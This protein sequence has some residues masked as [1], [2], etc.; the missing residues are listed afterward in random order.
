MRFRTRKQSLLGELI[1]LRAPGK[2][3]SPSA[4]SF[5]SS[6]VVGAS[7]ADERPPRTFR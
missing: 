5:F 6:A 7:G 2:A 1:V 3:G 4:L